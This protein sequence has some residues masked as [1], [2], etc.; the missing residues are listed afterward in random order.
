M[1]SVMT[2]N[3]ENFERPAAN[4]EQA[5]KDR[6]ARKLQQIKDVITSAGPD[7][8]GVQEVLAD[9]RNLEP[10]S[11]ADLLAAL[12]PEWNGCLSQRP[13][14]R[15]IRVGW[16]ARGQLTNPTDVAAYPSRV[17]PTTTDDDGNQIT[18]ITASK[19]GALAVTYG[20]ADGL[21]VQALTA[22]LKSKLLTF[23][24]RDP[25][26]PRFD[27][28]D[29]AER[30]RI[31][32]YALHQRAAEAATIRA[33]ATD[34]LQGQGQQRHL[35]VCGDLNDTPQAATTQLLLGRPGSQ[36][37]TGG[38]NQPDSGDGNRLWN[39]APKMPA[40]D[41]VTG[42]GAANWSRINNGVKELIDQILA[43]HQLVHALEGTES[44]PLEGIK[45]VTADPAS[46]A[47]L[48]APSDHRPVIA[49]F[50]L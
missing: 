38:F 4:A 35:L 10:Q 34:Q 36:L 41:P 1:F 2:W 13:D 31:G 6:Y 48:E 15:G 24:G 49:R 29:E 22:H 12:G 32:L 46:L 23:P 21:V 39:L 8:V 42:Q 47:E 50:N 5:A 43:S 33:W 27:T 45:S 28:R 18:A 11:F 20:R 40:G 14:P 16:L 30:A 3:L 19:R 7:L 44:L 26:H 37:G 9:R 17:P 25:Q